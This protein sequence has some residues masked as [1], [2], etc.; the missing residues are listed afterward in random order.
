MAR[1]QFSWRAAGAA[2]ACGGALML[3]ACGDDRFPDYRYRMTVEVQTPD[4]IK[5][6]SSVIE[7]KTKEI[8]TILDASGK[9]YK[10]EVHGEAVAVDV[11]P[12]KTLFALLSQPTNADYAK[13]VAFVALKPV[14]TTSGDIEGYREYLSQMVEVDGAHELPRDHWPIFVTFMDI[15][16]PQ[17]VDE[18]NS[19]SLQN[20]FGSEYEIKRVV[21]EITYDPV[22]TGIEKRFPWWKEYRNKHF[23]GSTTIIER[24]EY[25]DISERLSSGSFST[26]FNK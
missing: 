10:D 22:N 19:A 4:G 25:D 2:L 3:S 9:T 23:V 7:V 24:I 14:R 1:S 11:A 20:V 12:G 18:V 13:K 21:I 8:S 15:N 26:E 6:G 5:T 16:D 17:T